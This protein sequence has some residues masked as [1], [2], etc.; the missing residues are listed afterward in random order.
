MN[1]LKSQLRYSTLFRNAKA[2]NEWRWVGRFFP[3]LTLQ[4]VAITTPLER[5]KMRVKLVIYNQIPTICWKFGE[6][7]SGG[8]WDN[9]S[10]K[11]ILR[12]ETTGCTSLVLLNSGVIGPKFT[13]FTYTKARSSQMYTHELHDFRLWGL[14]EGT[15]MSQPFANTVSG[16]IICLVPARK[17]S[18]SRLRCHRDHAACRRLRD[19]I[20]G[21]TRVRSLSVQSYT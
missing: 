3:F 15:S 18:R 11:Y 20:E 16:T 1:L 13:K 19:V 17:R 9:L 10:K 12:K 7:R 8:F 21:S 4:L 14:R 6:N 5:S 2:M